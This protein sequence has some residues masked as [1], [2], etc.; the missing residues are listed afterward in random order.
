MIS[1]DLGQYDPI[2]PTI[3]ELS[4]TFHT[5]VTIPNNSV[6]ETTA[7]VIITN[8]RGIDER[9]RSYRTWPTWPWECRRRRGGYV[10][11]GGIDSSLQVPKVSLFL[12]SVYPLCILS[13]KEFTVGVIKNS[14]P[15]LGT[16]REK[17]IKLA[18]YSH[19]STTQGHISTVLFSSCITIFAYWIWFIFIFIMIILLKL[20]LI[21]KY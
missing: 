4:T 21:N 18:A 13:H 19:P 12:V 11:G 20:L 7:I 16:N 10:G 3:P 8:V 6:P 9:V 1:K 5:P 2:F 17:V 15:I 14:Q